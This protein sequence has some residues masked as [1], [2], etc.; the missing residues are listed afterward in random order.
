M[1]NDEAPKR[2]LEFPNRGKTP[3]GNGAFCSFFSFSFV[4]SVS[5]LPLFFNDQHSTSTKL[6]CNKTQQEATPTRK[7]ATKTSAG[8]SCAPASLKPR[9]CVIRSDVASTAQILLSGT[10]RAQPRARPCPHRARR[11]PRCRAAGA[12][13]TR[14]GTMRRSSPSR[15][16]TWSWG[17]SQAACAPW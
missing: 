7:H 17:C 10:T 2:T 15:R 1:C 5:P 3:T 16:R 14:S 11:R 13:R 6:A 8:A 9:K 12:A 4:S